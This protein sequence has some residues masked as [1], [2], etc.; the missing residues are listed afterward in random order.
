MAAMSIDVVS[1]RELVRL[2]GSRRSARAAV[3]A[4]NWWRVVR[5]AYAARHVPDSPE[6]RARALRLVLPP[7]VALSHRAAL[8]VLGVDVLARD[9]HSGLDLL[10][11]TTGRGTHLTARRG[12]RTHSARLTD[13]ELCEVDGLL[14]VTAPRAFV[15]VARSETLVEAVAFGDAVLRSGAATPQLLE[16]A[17]DRSTGL[18]GVRRARDAVRHLEPRSESLM[19]SR[20]RMKLLAGGVPPMDVQLDVYDDEGQHVGRGDLH[21]DG[22]VIE[23]DG[24]RE[25]LERARFTSDRRRQTGFAQLALEVR[26]FTAPDVYQRSDASVAAEVLRAARQAAGRDRSRVRRGP[27]TLRAPQLRPLPSLAELAAARAA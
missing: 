10:D 13:D 14:V 18:R 21:L 2:T 11:V 17:L 27:D 22:V 19:E 25:R 9:R 5:G 15:D 26:R 7:G 24:R 4:G 12:L 6:L 16:Q 8:W 3:A 23:Y 1:A 20:L